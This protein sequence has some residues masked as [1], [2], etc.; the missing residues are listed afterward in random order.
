MRTSVTS[1]ANFY[2]RPFGRL[3]QRTI[4]RK[5]VQAWDTADRL[6]VVGVGY[7][8]PFLN[9]FS[10]AERRMALIPEGIGVEVDTAYPACLTH[11]HR[12][13]FPD[14]S[15]DRLLIIHGLE[16]V[17]GPRRFLREAWRVL[18]DDGLI[19][20]ACANRRG[21]W[22]L[23]ETTPFAAGRPYSRRQLDALL[24]ATQF[25][26]TAHATALHFPPI[27]NPVIR[28]VAMAW[29]DIGATI[30]SWRLPPIFPN[31][32]GVNFVEARKATALPVGGS[33]VEVFRPGI[34]LPGGM[35]QPVRRQGAPARKAPLPQEG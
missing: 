31:L 26:P 33:K 12:W 27:D 20:I 35:P 11:D 7:P 28:R 9:G 17:A 14:A 32:A 21:P 6:R 10:G 30:E 22:A 15:I 2:R 34:L 18:T 25:Q 13:P 24:E 8:A 5:L 1:F 19:I 16:E 3:V 29:E 23:A 4:S